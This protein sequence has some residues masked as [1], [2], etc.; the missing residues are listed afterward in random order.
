MH[1]ISF[2]TTLLFFFKPLDVLNK[3]KDDLDA[4]KLS[5]IVSGRAYL[6]MLRNFRGIGKNTVE[7]VL[8]HKDSYYIV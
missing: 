6:K 4:S 8:T 5:T 1:H 3:V 7:D 2:K